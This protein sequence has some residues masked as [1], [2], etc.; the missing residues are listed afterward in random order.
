MASFAT[1][2]TLITDAAVELGLTSSAI[3][4]PYASTDANILRLNALLNAAGKRLYKAHQWPHLRLNGTI[5]TAAGTAVYT[6]TGLDRIIPDTM[7]NRTTSLPVSGPLSPQEWEYLQANPV[8]TTVTQWFRVGDLTTNNLFAVT[9]YPTPTAIQTIGFSGMTKFWARATASAAPD[10]EVP[11]VSS[12]VIY[13]DPWLVVCCLRMLFQRASGQ[14]S[15]AAQQD[16]EEAL[17]LAKA[18]ATVGRR[19]SLVGARGAPMLDGDNVPD[20]GF[21]A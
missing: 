16:Y 10:K 21:G 13:F 20:T 18:H 15:T 5:T 11:T 19:I 7:W 17:D 8:T 14:D 4:N 2:A 9:I 6:P 12:D 3:A 1:V